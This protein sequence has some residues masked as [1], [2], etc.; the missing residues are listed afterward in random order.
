MRQPVDVNK[1]RL[2]SV[3]YYLG[4]HNVDDN[5]TR[6][7]PV[8]IDSGQNGGYVV[9]AQLG[10]MNPWYLNSEPHDRYFTMKNRTKKFGYSTYWKYKVGTSFAT[11]A[12]AVYHF[13]R[14]VYGDLKPK[15][16]E[17]AVS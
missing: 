2:V 17:V 9:R 1:L 12:G 14:V 6:T 7:V 3:Q 15:P 8:F 10:G 4:K 16:P 11:V 13:N 5:I